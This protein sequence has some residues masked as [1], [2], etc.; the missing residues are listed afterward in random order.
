MIVLYVIT[1]YLATERE[2]LVSQLVVKLEVGFSHMIQR[3][4][5]VALITLI[6]TSTVFH[7]PKCKPMTRNWKL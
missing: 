6:L 1:K 3:C 2:L 5:P 4:S 7:F